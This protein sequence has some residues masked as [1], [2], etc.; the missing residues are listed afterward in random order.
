M[1]IQLFWQRPFQIHEWALERDLRNIIE[2]KLDYPK[3]KREYVDEMKISL[4]S[5]GEHI[6]LENDNNKRSKE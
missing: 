2:N 1:I 5:R 6:P 4:N 3:Y